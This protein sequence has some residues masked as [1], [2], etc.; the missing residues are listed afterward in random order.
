MICPVVCLN[1]MTFPFFQNGPH[2]QARVHRDEGELGDI[3]VSKYMVFFSPHVRGESLGTTTCPKAVVGGRQWHAPCKVL[4][5]QQGL[6]FV[7]FEFHGDHK[8][9]HKTVYFMEII[10]LFISWRSQER[11]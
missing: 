4:L 5:L 3:V 11:S 7:S 8:R 1:L 2:L 9:D 10:R 6:L